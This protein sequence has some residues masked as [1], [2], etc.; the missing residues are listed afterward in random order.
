MTTETVFTIR[1]AALYRI[2]GNAQTVVSKEGKK[3]AF[4]KQILN[5]FNNDESS[6]TL[7][8]LGNMVIQ[9]NH[10]G[11]LAQFPID[12]VDILGEMIIYIINYYRSNP[13]L[14]SKI[15]TM[16]GISA[17]D[18]IYGD[19]HRHQLMVATPNA[20]FL[21]LATLNDELYKLSKEID[22]KVRVEF[23][24]NP[25]THLFHPES[26]FIRVVANV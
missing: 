19:G 5:E 7:D 11:A 8:A 24:V 3:G 26:Q 22:V 2:I 10:E 17:I 15:A 16:C 12:D 6:A 20:R 1:A 21:E 25:D 9:M 13:E 14:A 23:F 4:L 18:S